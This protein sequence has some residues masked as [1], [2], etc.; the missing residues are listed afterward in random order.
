MT[1]E[2]TLFGFGEDRPPRFRG[3]NRLQLEINTPATPWA[4]LRAAG[5]DDE[6][7][8]VL[9]NRDTVIPAQH[10]DDNIIQDQDHLTLLSAFEGG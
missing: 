7:G 5:I 3:E 1:I 9:M 6:T 2:I 4:V 10:W 8:L